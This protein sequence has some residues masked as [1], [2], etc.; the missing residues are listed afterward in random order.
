MT[1]HMIR[2]IDG[3]TNPPQVI[4]EH[5]CYRDPEKIARLSEQGHLV[6]EVYEV[7]E[8]ERKL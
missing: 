4:E 7:T 5:Q 8:T 3:R 2:L 1:H 6:V